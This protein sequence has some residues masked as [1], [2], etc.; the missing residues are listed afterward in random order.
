MPRLTPKSTVQAQLRQLGKLAAQM[1]A[2]P[3]QHPLDV[4][5]SYFRLNALER[6]I[7]LE[8]YNSNDDDPIAPRIR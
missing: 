8:A 1:N 2:N 3:F 7:L 6:Q 4:I 5:A